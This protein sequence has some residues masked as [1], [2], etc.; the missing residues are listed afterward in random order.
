MTASLTGVDF[1]DCKRITDILLNS[2]GC[3]MFVRPVDPVKDNLPTYFDI[4]KDPQDL[5]TIRSRLEEGYY[6]SFADWEYAIDLVWS[7][8]QR[9]NRRDS[10]VNIV[11]KAMSVKC[12]KLK[13]KYHSFTVSSWQEC[14]TRLYEKLNVDMRSCPALVKQHFEGKEFDGPVTAAEL[15]RL[16]R[17][18][19]KLTDRT[20]VIQLIQV[21]SYF[22]VE[23]DLSKEE[24]FI[25]VKSLPVDALKAL[26]AFVKERYRSLKLPYPT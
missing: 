5:G 25:A 12:E 17:A 18:A 6:K 7:N 24:N 1:E 8:A 3:H 13:R 4:V 2:P 14:V 11:A 16:V 9:F 22:G 15:Q 10:L 23:L 20:E 19:S 26:T 21:L